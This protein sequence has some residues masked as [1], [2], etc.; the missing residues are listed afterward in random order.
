MSCD[1]LGDGDADGI[2]M[3]GIISCD[4]LGEGDAVGICIPGI[5]SCDGPGEGDAVG[6]CIPGIISCDGPG[7]GFFVVV[8][9]PAVRLSLG[10]GFFFLA[11]L[12]RFG[13]LIPGILLMS[14]PCGILLMSC[15]GN[16]FRPTAQISAIAP[17]ARR[18]ILKL[19]GR[20][21]IPPYIVRESEHSQVVDYDGNE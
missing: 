3:P 7:L 2:C 20:F 5:I 9:F 17:S 21:I 10:R 14:C 19:L 16:T 4:G 15:C 6:I 8:F 18:A 11:A 1:G 12:L 13:L